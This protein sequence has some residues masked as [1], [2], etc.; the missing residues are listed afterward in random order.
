MVCLPLCVGRILGDDWEKFFKEK[1]S[2][3][4]FVETPAGYRLAAGSHFFQHVEP[5]RHEPVYHSARIQRRHGR[6]GEILYFMAFRRGA[7]I[8][9]RRK[10]ARQ[11]YL[12][13][14]QPVGRHRTYYS[15]YS[16]S[17]EAVFGCFPHGPVELRIGRQL[18]PGVKPTVSGCSMS[19]IRKT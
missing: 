16:P 7:R 15:E 1:V 17:L 18:F 8:A 12:F 3:G 11:A 2:F 19:L 9:W 4:G 10:A 14:A 6:V 13:P 5:F